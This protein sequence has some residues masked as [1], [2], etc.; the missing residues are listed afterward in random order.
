MEINCF[1][2]LIFL[3][4]ITKSEKEN[5]LSLQ[6]RHKERLRDRKRE[7]QQR[8]GTQAVRQGGGN[9]ER[10]RDKETEG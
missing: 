8:D 3:H 7:R 1:Y 9:T 6:Q 5:L 10:I 2:L 4:L